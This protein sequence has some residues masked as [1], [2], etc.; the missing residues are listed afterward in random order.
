MPRGCECRAPYRARG[1]G[2]SRRGGGAVGDGAGCKGNSWE[3]SFRRELS[4]TLESMVRNAKIGWCRDRMRH[5][6]SSSD[7]L[8]RSSASGAVYA[9]SFYCPWHRTTGFSLHDRRMDCHGSEWLYR[10]NDFGHLDRNIYPWEPRSR[11]HHG[12]CLVLGCLVPPSVALGR[13]RLVLAEVSGWV[14]PP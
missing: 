7:P 11:V 8:E 1:R 5:C 9:Y 2:V 3:L 14:S 6:S 4:R 10:R 13:R 12:G